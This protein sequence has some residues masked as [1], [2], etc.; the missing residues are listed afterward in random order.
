MNLHAYLQAAG[1]DREAYAQATR[2]LELDENLVV[3]RVSITHFHADWGELPEAVAAARKAYAVGPWYP[4]AVA[5]LAALL[6]QTGEEDE[7]RALYESLGA[8]EAGGEARAQA[9][10]YLMCGEVDTAADWVEKAVI[11]RD[12]SMMYYLRFVVSRQLR[13]SH[14]WPA[15]AQMLNLPG[16]SL[17]QS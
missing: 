7:A 10:Y 16:G 8:G 1:Q 15:I 3:A 6:R 12:N 14:R 9:V 11:A 5:S 4:D 2:V 13:A 17:I